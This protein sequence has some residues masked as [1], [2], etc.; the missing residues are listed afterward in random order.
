MAESIS[1]S[2][3]WFAFAPCSWGASVSAL[4]W[5]AYLSA[6]ARGQASSRAWLAP[7][8]RGGG[9]ERAASPITVTPPPR[10][11]TRYLA[12]Y[13]GTLLALVT[14]LPETVTPQVTLAL[15]RCLVTGVLHTV[16]SAG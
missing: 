6:F 14:G 7:W 4:A 3:A 13:Q 2:A 16:P 8:A 11:R 1:V 5:A 12:A 9:I 15:A 10:H